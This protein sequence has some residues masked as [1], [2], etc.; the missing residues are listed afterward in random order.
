MEVRLSVATE[1]EPHIDCTQ[2]HTHTRTHRHLHYVLQGTNLIFK[3]LA[4]PGCDNQFPLSLSLSPLTLF[5]YIYTQE[6][7]EQ[8]TDAIQVSGCHSNGSPFP[9]VVLLNCFKIPDIR[10]TN[11]KAKYMTVTIY[12]SISQ[13]ISHQTLCTIKH[14]NLEPLLLSREGQNHGKYPK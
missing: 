8:C 13:A 11:T 7:Q 6:P 4:I 12:D 9:S 5:L 14:S 1:S 10:N 3:T 2:T